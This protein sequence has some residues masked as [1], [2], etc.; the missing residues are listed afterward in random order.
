[1]QRLA[2]ERNIRGLLPLLDH[3]DALVREE[4]ARTLSH[5]AEDDLAPFLELLR[6]GNRE[7][8]RRTIEVLAARPGFDAA[9]LIPALGDDTGRVYP[10]VAT[11]CAR[12]GEEAIPGLVQALASGR[13]ELW[14]GAVLALREM[15]RT[16]W[17]ALKARLADPSHRVRLG[18][19]RALEQS[20]WTPA[21]EREEFAYRFAL[22]DWDAIIRMHKVAVPHLIGA[23]RDPH[24]GIREAA[25]RTLGRIGDVAAFPPLAGLL[26]HDP[27]EEVRAAAAESLGLLGEPRAIP[28]L[29]GALHDRSHAVRLAAAGALETF[30]WLPETEEET[31]AL[32][33]ATEQW[34]L[35]V[36]LGEP[37]VP[38]LIEALADDYFGI[39]TGA[40]EALLSLGPVG[41][42]ALEEARAHPNPTIRDG[43]IGLLVRAGPDA[44]AVAP[45]PEETAVSEGPIEPVTP[46]PPPALSPPPP[47]D[48]GRRPG[49]DRPLL[50]RLADLAARGAGAS[51]LRT[52]ISAPPSMHRET[53]I[54]EFIDEALRHGAE[55]GSRSP[56]GEL[57]ATLEEA[58]G[59]P[60]PALRLVAV[61]VFGRLGPDAVGPLLGAL[62]D[63][64]RLVRCAAID[65]LA[66][67]MDPRATAPLL[68][69]LRTDGEEEVREHAAWALGESGDP[70]VVPALIDALSDPYLRVRSAASAALTLFGPDV[71]PALRPVLERADLPAAIA[72]AHA[73]GALRDTASVPALLAL[74]AREEPDAGTAAIAALGGI[75]PAAAPPLADIA[76]D[77]ERPTAVRVR[78]IRA[79]TELGVVAE[80]R[81][82]PLADDPDPEVAE[83]ARTALASL[84]PPGLGGESG[85]PPVPS[86][87]EVVLPAAEEDEVT[88]E[89]WHREPVEVPVS[90]PSKAPTVPLSA[91]AP[92]GEEA[93]GPTGPAAPVGSSSP[94]EEEPAGTDA[95]SRDPVSVL[96]AALAGN[97]ADAPALLRRLGRTGDP[98]GLGPLAGR[99]FAGDPAE[100]RAA[101]EALRAIPAPGTVAALAGALLDPD[102]GVREEA[103]TSLGLLGTPMALRLV[104]D[105]LADPDY[106]VREAAVVSLGRAV[107]EALE[108]LVA[109]LG[110]PERE[111]RAGAARV[112]RGAGWQGADEEQALGF[113]LAS[114][115]W[116]L[117]GRFGEEALAPLSSLLVHPDPDLRLGAVIALGGIGGERATDLIRQAF[118]DP[119]PLVRNRAALL[120]HERKTD[121]AKG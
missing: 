28:L 27:E 26:T 24:F 101:A 118:S 105:R 55:A 31:I 35:L 14:R 2:A 71:L 39:R 77:A 45:G 115:D 114:E 25:A 120:L 62:E 13:E 78:A 32:L 95:A 43:A 75:G 84:R 38:A 48:R 97:P 53:A 65:A 104:V 22:E 6:T 23:L 99:L 109:A 36:R 47:E 111:V 87:R 91:F 41:R 57:L 89:A 103:V 59:E 46:V 9:R 68:V 50:V 58:L 49:G 11:L 94:P 10:A 76:A 63:P 67:L 83:T 1:V 19:A 20:K 98:R 106:A 110:H 61:E 82:V 81:L 80:E 92:P 74:L 56:P 42:R 102:P 7:V 54:R 121:E 52:R 73:L 116:R 60:D 108:P 100:R 15:G 44:G 66:G 64:D 29:R 107:P 30:G 113:A 18:A 70:G 85:A 34:P 37:A 86:V 96:L 5:L 4:A 79:L 33:L 3:R 51:P 21:D 72:A 12:Y 90:S 8:Q 112:L 88:L 40:G 117:L 93:P 17:P 16:A 69:R 119:S